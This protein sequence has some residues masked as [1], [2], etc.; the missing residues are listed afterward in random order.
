MSEDNFNN[1]GSGPKAPPLDPPCFQLNNISGK[2][3]RTWWRRPWLRDRAGASVPRMD[4]RNLEGRRGPRL[5]GQEGR[6]SHHWFSLIVSGLYNFQD[7]SRESIGFYKNLIVK[8][9]RKARTRRKCQL[10]WR[11]PFASIKALFCKNR[12]SP[13]CQKAKGTESSTC[14]FS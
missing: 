4:Q 9:K 13:S 1:W 11:F 7:E 10:H 6:V 12:H 5:L 8:G 2:R 3:N 14:L